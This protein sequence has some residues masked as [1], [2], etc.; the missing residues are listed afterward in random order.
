MKPTA[1][2][3][4][5]LF[6]YD[7]EKGILRRRNGMN[8]KITSVEVIEIRNRVAAGE[9]RKSLSVEFGISVPYIGNLVNGLGNLT[10]LNSSIS[11]R[12]T[13]LKTKTGTPTQ[14][15]VDSGAYLVHHI[16]WIY[17]TGSWPVLKIDHKDRNKANI[18]WD[19]LREATHGQNRANSRSSASSGFKGVYKRRRGQR[20]YAVIRVNREL[21]QLGSFF[22]P[23]EA[24]KAY[25]LAAEK[26]HGEFA[27]I[28]PCQ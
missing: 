10:H 2:R 20:W 5:E 3:I 14:L 16:V 24:A 19:N 22:S 8:Y 12:V 7:P 11:K 13:L 18:K 9:S 27:R 23:E 6:I 26:Y 25:K 1:E 4:R 28:K 17:M 21:I 15:A